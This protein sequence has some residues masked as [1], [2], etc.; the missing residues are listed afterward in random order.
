MPLESGK[1]YE[2]D[3][4][5]VIN[6]DVCEKE[7]IE[8]QVYLYDLD[9]FKQTLFEFNPTSTEDTLNDRWNHYTKCFQVLT[10]SY[11][12]FISI[13]STCKRTNRVFVAVDEIKVNE[14]MG[15]GLDEI[16]DDFRGTSYSIEDIYT[17]SSTITTPK[18]TISMTT[19]FDDS[20]NIITDDSLI[21]TSYSNEI[22][23]ISDYSTTFSTTTTQS[24]Q[25]F[26]PGLI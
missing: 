15:D 1:F 26:T 11:Q 5:N 3:F 18:T 7:D 6:T 21:T 12:L 9:S 25:I 24:T 8:F 14:I 13:N 23:S 4:R 10:E 20:T 2:F 22:S 16:C 19:N 17:Y